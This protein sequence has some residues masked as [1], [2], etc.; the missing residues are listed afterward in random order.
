MCVP[1]HCNC[2]VPASLGRYGV[3]VPFALV[4]CFALCLLQATEIS[5]DEDEFEVDAVSQ[6]ANALRA[7]KKERSRVKLDMIKWISAY[8]CFALAAHASHV[9]RFSLFLHL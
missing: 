6:L 4:Q 2:R 9:R 1:F 5:S 8:E 7:K 3:F